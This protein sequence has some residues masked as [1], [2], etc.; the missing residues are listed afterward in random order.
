MLARALLKSDRSK[1]NRCSYIDT[2]VDL[3]LA[4]LLS[5]YLDCARFEKKGTCIWCCMHLKWH[6]FIVQVI[7]WQRC[8]ELCTLTVRIK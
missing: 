1:T 2:K 6:F 8:T 5:S 3:C 4:V 7:V